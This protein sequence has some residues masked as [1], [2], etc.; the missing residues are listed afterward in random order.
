MT[1]RIRQ[2]LYFLSVFVLITAALDDRTAGQSVAQ[3]TASIRRTIGI[4]GPVFPGDFNGDGI[5]DLVGYSLPPGAEDDPPVITVV[6]GKGDGTYGP[7][8]RSMNMGYVLAVGDYNGDHKLDALVQAL[9][10]PDESIIVMVGKGDGTFSGSGGW[11]ADSFYNYFGLTGDLDG[12]GKLDVVDV[13]LF[14]TSGGDTEGIHIT[15]GNGDL[16]FAFETAVWIP[17]SAGPA[18]GAI[19]DLNGDGK[20]DIVIANSI[21]RSLTILMNQGGGLNFAAS[22][23]TL[24]RQPAGVA[25]EDVNHDGKADLVV[26]VSQIGL[27]RSHYLDGGAYLLLGRGKGTF[28]GP[29]FY[30]TV[31]GALRVVVADFTRDGFLDIATANL[32]AGFATDCGLSRRGWDSVS[33]LPGRS[34]GTFGAAS[35]F[36]LGDQRVPSDR[37]FTNTLI[38]LNVADV[39]G[40]RAFDLVAS[41]G[42]ILVNQP[43]DPN[44]PP[45]V[46]ARSTAPAPGSHSVVLTASADDVDQDLLTYLWTDNHGEAVAPVPDPC[47]TPSTLGVH[48]FT[49]TVN[50]GHGHSASSSVTVDFGGVTNAIVNIAA[51][52][53]HEVVAANT[54]YAIRWTATAGT[55]P[56]AGFNVRVSFDNGA[57][58]SAIA[59]CT[60]LA[61]SATSCQ[62]NNPAPATERALVTVEAIATTGPGS[63]TTSSQFSIRSGSSQSLPNGW[64]HGDVGGVGAAGTASFDGYQ[65]FGEAYTVAGSGADIWGTADEFHYAWKSVTGDFEINARVGSVDA[66]HAWTK[67][68]LTVRASA[69]D[70]ASP[71]VSLFVT[72]GKGIALQHRVVEGGPSYNLSGP[73][74]AAP[75]YLRLVRAG[76]DVHAFYRK[77]PTDPWTML[78]SRRME[79]F[80]STVDVGLAVTSH[81]DGKVATAKFAGVRL[82]SLPSWTSTTIGSAT[83]AATNSAATT[84]FMHGSGAD[85]W[86]TS[87]AFQY[88][89]VPLSGGATI[90]VRVL[91]VQNTSAWAKAGVMVR[92]SLAPGA[93]YVDAVVTPGKGIA[94]QYRNTTNG[95]A[96]SVA[97]KTGA[98]P[99]WLRLSRG[100]GM[101]PGAVGDVIVWYSTDGVIWR[102]LGTATFNM[103]HDIYIGLAVTSHNASAEATATFDDVRIDR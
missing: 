17:S 2:R 82:A 21:D 88:M 52:A 50:D 68:G 18:G 20:N 4:D 86:G 61:E 5:V 70:P 79:G 48:T 22:E 16:T 63:S 83:G 36:S 25:I 91:K 85:I 14:E 40:D 8:I 47:F 69:T 75:V 6:L 64:S 7:P 46:T 1:R 34:D 15:H 55:Y 35:S 37:R 3:P 10:L 73:A 19:A 77:K 96:A 42:A 44:W 60:N 51:P 12:D 56:I 67:A 28:G 62:W 33:I 43:A 80:S 72:P 99:V 49:V 41:N 84:Y 58:F 94:M 97:Q 78:S 100:E 66:V 24:D 102:V 11:V 39:N 23:I 38:S 98:A 32:A 89:W 87:D 53:L 57:H 54:P 9:P 29:V 31:P 101:N 65:Y 74:Y 92:E 93:K 103:A 30:P 13:G 81:A 59:E 71:H 90:T 45:T 27:D 95:V 76:A 26:A